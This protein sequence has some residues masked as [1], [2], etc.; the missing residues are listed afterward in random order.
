M[1]GTIKKPEESCLNIFFTQELHTIYWTEKYMTNI[2]PKIHNAATSE[3]LRYFILDHMAET[4]THITR[5]EKIFDLM[6]IKAKPKKCE[7]VEGLFKEVENMIK[8]TPEGSSTRDAALIIGAQKVEHYEIATYGGLVQ[9]ATTLGFEKIT[10]L[11][12]RTLQDE[13]DADILYSDLAEKK[14]NWLAETEK[15]EA[16]PLSFR[17]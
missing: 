4:E 15:K 5:L 3:Q 6:G 2:L 9:L 14:V 7:A 11:L 13:K 1:E 8:E 17:D 12:E 16:Q 10:R